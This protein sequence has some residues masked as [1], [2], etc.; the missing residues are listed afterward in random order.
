MIGMFFKYVTLEESSSLF[1]FTESSRQIELVVVSLPLSIDPHILLIV[2]VSSFTQKLLR[3]KFV[4]SSVEFKKSDVIYELGIIDRV[5]VDE[6]LQ[7]SIEIEEQLLPL[8]EIVGILERKI[9]E[10]PSLQ[11]VESLLYR[12]SK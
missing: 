6:T 4:S 2:L 7:V 12:Q 10:A 5:E 9:P 3:L 1:R 11:S 8:V